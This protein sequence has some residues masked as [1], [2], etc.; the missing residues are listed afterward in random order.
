MKCL[1]VEDNF[2]A[3][4]ILQTYLSDYGDCFIAVNGYE[5][6]EAVREALEQG[7]PYD[8][9]CLDIILPRMNGYNA[10]KAIRQMEKEQGIE[11]LDCARVIVTTVLR[12][13]ES[14]V[15]AFRQGCEA[16]IVKPVTKEKLLKEMKNCGLVKSEVNV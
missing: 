8:L 9:I 1:I 3:R 13:A 4:K 12:D 7:E 10:L 11:G 16:Y 6:V 2:A 14:I 15:S 5:A